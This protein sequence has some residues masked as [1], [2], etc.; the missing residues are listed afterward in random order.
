MTEKKRVEGS[1]KYNIY[2]LSICKIID[3]K[4]LKMVTFLFCGWTLHVLCF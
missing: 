1:C 4:A 2:K 3:S